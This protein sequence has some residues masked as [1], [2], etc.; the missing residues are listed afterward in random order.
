MF[1]VKHSLIVLSALIILRVVDPWPI[2]TL[3]LKYFDSLFTLKDT[4]PS[5]YIAIHDIDEAA[6]EKHGQWPWPR[7]ELARLNNELLEGGAAAVVCH[8][9]VTPA[10]TIGVPIAIGRKSGKPF[11]SQKRRLG[12][13]KPRHRRSKS[14]YHRFE[15]RSNKMSKCCRESWLNSHG[16]S[17]CC[18]RWL[19]TGRR[20][21]KTYITDAGT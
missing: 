17:N 6:L 9:E 5:D 8:F 14:R 2:E 19:T 13:S 4:V 10:T 12:R 7:Q 11:R 18:E 1:H 16:G 15:T 21:N 20:R 3:R